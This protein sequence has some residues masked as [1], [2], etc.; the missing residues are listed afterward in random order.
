[1]SLRSCANRTALPLVGRRGQ[2]PQAVAFRMPCIA[3]P[4]A[5]RRSGPARGVERT[6]AGQH[7]AGRPHGPLEREEPHPETRDS[8][9]QWGVW[10]A[11]PSRVGGTPQR[12]GAGLS[13]GT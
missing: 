5:R 2:L 12:A 10:S 13:P 11:R 6:A 3:N 8:P 9:G 4:S 1:L 7:N